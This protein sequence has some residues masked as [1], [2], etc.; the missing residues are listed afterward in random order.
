VLDSW[1][2]WAR[3]SIVR[4]DKTNLETG[5]GPGNTSKPQSAFMST[6]SDN[7]TCFLA[8]KD[9][10]AS[11]LIS[12]GDMLLNIMRLD[13]RRH[14]GNRHKAASAAAKDVRKATNLNDDDDA[15]EF[16]TRSSI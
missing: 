5:I 6:L 13:D 12:I 1:K 3:N 10:I 4:S 7:K 9:I 8:G 2:I 14:I 11:L 16:D 15:R